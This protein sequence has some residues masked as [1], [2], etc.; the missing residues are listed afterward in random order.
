MKQ[1]E[2]NKDK[3]L[4]GCTFKP[5]TNE[6]IKPGE[7]P[8]V[9]LDHLYGLGKQANQNRK[10]KKK[11]DIHFESQKKECVFQPQIEQ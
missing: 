5:V 3:E 2:I 8:M 7:N 11:D 6:H 4:E 10:D 1:K 9:R